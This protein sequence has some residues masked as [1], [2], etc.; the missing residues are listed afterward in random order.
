MSIHLEALR[1]SGDYKSCGTKAVLQQDIASLAEIDRIAE[2]EKKQ[3]QQES[4][5]FWIITAVIVLSCFVI[6]GILETWLG[7][8]L[9]TLTLIALVLVGIFSAKKAIAANQKA[10]ERSQL[11][12][13][14]HR[15]RLLNRLVGL[16]ARDLPA[17][18]QLEVDLNLSLS[19][20]KAKLVRQI[21]H[22]RRPNW[23]IDIYTDPWL[24]IK[25]KFID[26]TRF[27]LQ[28]T[29]EQQ[30]RSGTNIHGKRRVRLRFKGVELRL[31]LI[32]P[33][34]RYP[35]GFS[36]QKAS[37][38]IHLPAG[39]TLKVLQVTSETLSLKAKFSPQ[40]VPEFVPRSANP[41]AVASNIPFSP[42][43]Q[44]QAE[45]AFEDQLYQAIA[46]MFLS[47]YQIL[48]PARK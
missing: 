31:E 30:I 26:G 36:L 11:D 44:L 45:Q 4:I 39:V 16:L 38:R 21:P 23:T 3:F 24:K 29:Q 9:A 6:P 19:D 33:P 18:G 35:T 1:Q 25:G 7:K 28:L 34:N 48:N 37:D 27:F 13:P 32:L 20:H 22:P 42:Q 17:K 5:K 12:F 46:L 8:S 15:Y 47:A 10:E 14:N 40:A 2:L 41:Q 43:L